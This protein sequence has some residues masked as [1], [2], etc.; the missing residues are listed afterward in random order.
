M[1]TDVRELTCDLEF[2]FKSER[3]SRGLFSIPE[4][5]VENGHVFLRRAI[6]EDDDP[7][8]NPC[9]LSYF[10]Y[11]SVYYLKKPQTLKK[12]VAISP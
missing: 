11:W 1:N 8:Q 9:E 7:P 6:G 5:S 4:R 2:L 12:S 10:F 3:N